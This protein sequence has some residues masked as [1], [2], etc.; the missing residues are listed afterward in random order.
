MFT[1][2]WRISGGIWGVMMVA[3]CVASML[4]LHHPVIEKVDSK[5][6]AIDA[7]FVARPDETQDIVV[8]TVPQVFSRYTSQADYRVIIEVLS[9]IKSANPLATALVLNVSEKMHLNAQNTEK[10][11]QELKA[12]VSKYPAFKLDK[13]K[14]LSNY[15]DQEIF[16]DSVLIES[17]LNKSLFVAQAES[18]GDKLQFNDNLYLP[19]EQ[20]NRVDQV[21]PQSLR[22]RVL[23]KV[24]N[25]KN[26]NLIAL[27]YNN[28]PAN[29]DVIDT[30]Y[31][32]LIWNINNQLLPDILTQLLAVMQGSQLPVWISGQGLKFDADFRRTDW[33]G[34]V[35][36]RSSVFTGIKHDFKSYTFFDV[37]NDKPKNFLKGKIVIVGYENDPA[38][39]DLALSLISLHTGSVYFSPLWTDLLVIGLL[40][41]TFLYSMFLLP[42]MQVGAGLILTLFVLFALLVGQMGL[43]LVQFV[44]APM[45]SVAIFLLFGHAL[46]L[47]RRKI[48]RR[49]DDLE[50]QVFEAHWM[51]GVYQFEQGEYDQSFASLQ[52]CPTTDLMLEQMYRIGQAYEKRRQYDKALD[53][54]RD[55]NAR[56]PGYKSADKRI[57]SLIQLEENQAGPLNVFSSART[58]IVTNHGLQKPVLGR[59][60]LVRELGRGAMGV[61]YLGKD[62]KIN[63][64]VAIKTMD[65]TQYDDNELHMVR[66]RFFR[67]AETAG[68]LNH[69]NIVTIYDVGEEQ[70]LAFIAM[71]YVI[72]QVMSDF[73]RKDRLLPVDMVFK[74]MR[75][76]A[77]ALDYAHKQGVVHRDIKPS[78]IMY[79]TE[80]QV[81]KVTD[82][83]IARAA[84]ATG[85]NTGSI[86]GSPLYM[87]PEQLSGI[88]V[89]GRADLFSLGVSMYQLLTGVL[90]FQGD[91]L[92]SL[93]YQVTNVKHPPIREIRSDLPQLTTRFIN[94]MLQKD[95]EKRF[96][97][98]KEVA[99]AIIKVLETVEEDSSSKG[100]RPAPK[101]SAGK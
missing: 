76:V 79:N 15:S 6:F 38:V 18:Q 35:L 42:R 71:D 50:Q 10:F 16:A 82:F 95:P 56:R 69:P 54:Y 86:L 65:L 84:G 23:P 98:G 11:L 57:K 19:S 29:G 46:S 47:V 40:I 58:L 51:L 62:P 2:V 53:L 43:L 67:E 77:I 100:R 1:K 28:L 25:V 64:Q 17:L 61:V 7:Q 101:K 63:R 3:L 90:P 37:L 94:K 78:N 27:N 59:Y 48:A 22:K 73:V 45:T 70:D 74:L 89:D 92:A 32:S 91:T 96:A 52:K 13:L 14:V 83:G 12:E 9:E 75:Q 20:L 31:R 44:W 41:I 30:A 21:L 5:M 93:A 24:A 55:L 81:I 72:G 85:T 26:A 88:K 8:V 80:E 66:E 87:A 33:G 99:A 34:R 39:E 68:R 4:T 49:Y 36:P 97:S 60:E